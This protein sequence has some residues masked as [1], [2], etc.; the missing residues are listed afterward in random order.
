MVASTNDSSQN[1]EDDDYY[2]ETLGGENDEDSDEL[3]FSEVKL[4]RKGRI[5]VRCTAY[6]S[7]SARYARFYC[8]WYIKK[9]SRILKE[10][11]QNLEKFG[12]KC[13]VKNLEPSD[14]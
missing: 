6:L 9:P 2:E 14:E 10:L 5:S 3:P 11:Q 8:D 13:E 4:L 1:D 12:Q 7:N